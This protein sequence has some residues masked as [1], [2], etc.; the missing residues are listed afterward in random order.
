M[1][2]HQPPCVSHAEL[3]KLGVAKR[4]DCT[5]HKFPMWDATTPEP[6]TKKEWDAM[7]ALIDGNCAIDGYLMQKR[8]ARA[9][10][11]ALRFLEASTQTRQGS[12]RLSNEAAEDIAN[13]PDVRYYETLEHMKIGPK[14]ERLRQLEIDAKCVMTNGKSINWADFNEELVQQTDYVIEN[15]AKTAFVCLGHVAKK[16]HSKNSSTARYTT[17]PI[18]HRPWKG[19]PFL[20]VVLVC[21]SVRGNGRWLMDTIDGMTAYLGVRD[22]VLSAMPN[23][24]NFYLKFGY[25]FM[26]RTMRGIRSITCVVDADSTDEMRPARSRSRRAATRPRTRQSPPTLRPRL[27]R[28]ARLRDGPSKRR[29]NGSA[30]RPR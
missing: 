7:D 24:L 19:R 15:Q 21:S 23:V 10:A 8:V 28:S 25:R 16:Q 5:Y 4:A 18:T 30:R 29:G 17:S 3:I 1:P 11:P 14:K 12:R 6:K 9:D 22:I 26:H 20:Y 2:R 27:R 13:A